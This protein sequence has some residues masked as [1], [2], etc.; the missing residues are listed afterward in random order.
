MSL[1]SSGIVPSIKS[2]SF[3][4]NTIPLPL[5]FSLSF[6]IPSFSS[7]CPTFKISAN[8]LRDIGSPFQNNIASI[9]FSKLIMN[10]SN[11]YSLHNNVCAIILLHCI[12]NS[13]P[14]KLEHRQEPDDDHHFLLAVRDFAVE[15]F[16]I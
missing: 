9:L 11:F 5:K 13:L 2:F 14:Y 6:S 1:E 16:E 15:I 3:S 12:H 4:I 7:V 10:F 8:F